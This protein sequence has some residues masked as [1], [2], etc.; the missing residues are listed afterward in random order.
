MAQFIRFFDMN[1][2][3][4]IASLTGS[5]SDEQPPMKQTAELV[6]N[7]ETQQW[8]NVITIEPLSEEEV[9]RRNAEPRPTKADENRELRTIL[10]SMTDEYAI[11]DRPLSDAMRE[12]RQ[13][14]RDITTHPNWPNLEEGDWPVKPE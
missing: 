6:F 5:S 1:Y 8:E 10:L 2:E 3:E 7:A 14:L 9:A 13:A 12:Y 4:A 11:S